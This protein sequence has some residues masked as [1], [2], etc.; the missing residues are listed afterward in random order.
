[1]TL[2]SRNDPGITWWPWCLVMTLVSRN[3]PGI[4]WWPWCL[5][6]TLVSRDDPGISWWPWC[7][8]MTLASRDNPGISW[9]PWYL[10]MRDI[11]SQTMPLINI[12]SQKVNWVD[13]AY[14]RVILKCWLPA[15]M[16]QSVPV[17]LV[18]L[19]PSTH[20][21]SVINWI[22]IN[23]NYI[24]LSKKNCMK[25]SFAYMFWYRFYPN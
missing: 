22:L 6:M 3:D 20:N 1:M 2:V 11:S 9:L 17:L 8:V 5:E 25:S 13:H 7:L 24:D 15:V 16:S 12:G 18:V 23:T 14:S 21:N 10:V 19:Q 4:S